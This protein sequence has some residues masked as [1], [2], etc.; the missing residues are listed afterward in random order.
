MNQRPVIKLE[1]SPVDVSVEGISVSLVLLLVFIPIY[2]FGQLPDTIPTH[3]NARGVADG[4]GSKWTLLILPSMGTLMFVGLSILNRFPH[5]FNYP[6]EITE[7]NAERQYR[8]GTRL[9]RAINLIIVAS[10]C[11]I[12]WRIIDS[13]SEVQGSLGPYFLPIFVGLI[14]GVIVLYFWKSRN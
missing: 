14:F 6:V 3:F 5:D 8:N 4:F 10:F 11:F 2:F 9:I 13:A 7:E 12:E 1:K